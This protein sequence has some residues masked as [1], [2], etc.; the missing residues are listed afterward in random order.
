MLTTKTT[1]DTSLE[2]HPA[3]KIHHELIR[4]EGSITKN[5]NTL[6]GSLGELHAEIRRITKSALDGILTKE[7]VSTERNALNIKFITA[8]KLLTKATSDIEKTITACNTLAIY[9]LNKDEFL[10]IERVEPKSAVT[11]HKH[12]QT[13]VGSAFPF[14]SKLFSKI[15]ST[16]ESVHNLYQK[17]NTDDQTLR[18]KYSL[19]QKFSCLSE[20]TTTALSYQPPKSPTFTPVVNIDS[21]N[22]DHPFGKKKL[23]TQ[24]VYDQ[25]F[26]QH[27]ELQA[28][29]ENFYT[30]E[31]EP[32]SKTIS[33]LKGQLNSS[34]PKKSLF[35]CLLYVSLRRYKLLSDRHT[36]DSL[37]KEQKETLDYLKH[38]ISNEASE[39]IDTIETNAGKSF[40]GLF[41]EQKKQHKEWQDLLNTTTK[42]SENYQYTCSDVAPF[43][44]FRYAIRDIIEVNPS[45]LSWGL[46]KLKQFGKQYWD[47]PIEEII[48]LCLETLKELYKLDRGTS[49]TKLLQNLPKEHVV[50]SEENTE[51]S[52]KVTSFPI[53]DLSIL[54]NGF[55]NSSKKSSLKD[56]KKVNNQ[57]ETVESKASV[58][59]KNSDDQLTSAFKNLSLQTQNE[60]LKGAWAK[61]D[62]KEEKNNKLKLMN[63]QSP[64]EKQPFKNLTLQPPMPPK[65]GKRNNPFKKK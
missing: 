29:L 43:N 15:K 10:A 53:P 28:E 45:W 47:K 35:T 42:L 51:N 12:V 20:I 16:F 46:E 3:L 24:Q 34:T 8:N 17:V 59:S 30:T 13:C 6:N 40:N 33:D 7:K 19:D 14:A 64:K 9:C 44:N 32:L 11:Y 26:P 1:N 56:E 38:T 5:L 21:I 55:M 18:T 2:N 52:E 23:T 37:I 36:I 41:N 54:L 58:E 31:H 60:K 61:K 49:H 39:T 50:L 25:N 62:E 63:L 4:D 48:P 22:T 65:K 57:K 27:K